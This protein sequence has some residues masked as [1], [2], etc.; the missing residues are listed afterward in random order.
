MT[1]DLRNYDP[2]LMQGAA[3]SGVT[4]IV[5]TAATANAFAVGANGV[6]N[7]VLN[8]DSSTS[9]VASGLSITGAATGTAVALAA[10]D[11]GS[12]GHMTLAGKGTGG[13]VNVG[14]RV[15]T[16]V[17]GSGS[18][19]TLTASQSGS[20]VLLD[21]AAGIVFTLP[22]NK[23]GMT[24][25]FFATVTVTSNNYK[26]ITAAGTELLIGGMMGDD[27]DSS[28]A[29][30]YFPAVSGSS[31]IAVLMDGI[32][33]GGLAGSHFV[34]TC[35]SATRWYVSGVTCATGSIATPFSAT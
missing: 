27:T 28:D 23:P 20:L 10:L 2:A 29:N 30:A 25:E 35:L 9:S 6:T 7:P 21:R 16:I 24:F 5:I 22:A 17:S 12:T 19:V 14:G 4:P 8:V 31:Y 15:Q 26:V 32:T 11:S 18:T 34:M 33:H 13:T 1:L 3:V